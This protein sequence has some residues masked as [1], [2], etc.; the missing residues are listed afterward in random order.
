MQG[1][2]WLP[3]GTVVRITIDDPDDTYYPYNGQLGVITHRM[4]MTEYEWTFPYLV[5]PLNDKTIELL[6]QKRELTVEQFISPR[7][8]NSNGQQRARKIAHRIRHE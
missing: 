3:V 6:L 5:Q 1:R 7:G 4:D 8:T 2:Y